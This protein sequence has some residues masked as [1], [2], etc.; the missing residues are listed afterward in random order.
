MPHGPIA[1]G[2]RLTNLATVWKLTAA[3]LK[4]HY[5]PRP[6][7]GSFLPP[8][9]FGWSP[10]CSSVELLRVLQDEWWDRWRRHLEVWLLSDGVRHAYGSIN[11]TTE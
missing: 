5:H 7:A 8:Y 3:L 4:D 11:H 10:R 9:R 1:N 6:L 2:R